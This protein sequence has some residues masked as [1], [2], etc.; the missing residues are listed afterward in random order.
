MSLSHWHSSLTGMITT[1]RCPL[2][3]TAGVVRHVAGSHNSPTCTPCYEAVGRHVN[4]WVEHWKWWHMQVTVSHFQAVLTRGESHSQLLHQGSSTC[5]ASYVLL[6]DMLDWWKQSLVAQSQELCKLGWL[7][8]AVRGLYSLS[9]YQF[10]LVA[11]L[12]LLG[13]V[14]VYSGSHCL[15]KSGVVGQKI[16]FIQTSCRVHQS[17]GSTLVSDSIHSYYSLTPCAIDSNGTKRLDDYH[18]TSQRYC[19]R[20]CKRRAGAGYQKNDASRRWSI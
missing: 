18:I 17:Q 20:R 2:S 1:N 6:R 15:K 13:R 12:R 8:C 4:R 9:L 3:H 14:V 5:A 10:M 19:L 11:G 16:S 7:G